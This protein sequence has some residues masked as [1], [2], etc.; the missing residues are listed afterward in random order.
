MLD[1]ARRYFDIARHPVPPEMRALLDARFAE[2]PEDLRGPRQTMGR[3]FTHCGYTLGAAY[4]SFGCTHCYLPRNANRAPLPSLDEMKAQIDANRRLMGP[5]GGLQL[6]GGDVVDAYWRAEKTDELVEIVRY[7]IDAEVEPMI[8]THGQ[9]LLD[10]PEYLD[11]LVVEGG[12]RKLA[13]HIDITQAGR[14]GFPLRELSNE[15]DLHPL[16]ER[17]VDLVIGCRERTGERFFAAHTVT[18]TERNLDSIAEIPRWLLADPRRLEAFRMVSFQTEAAVGRTRFSENPV[19]PETTWARICEGVGIPLDRDNVT[20]G[21]PDCSNMTTVMAL[22]PERRVVNLMP[23][24]DA[25]KAFAEVYLDTIRRLGSRGHVPFERNLRRLMMI[26]R[27]PHFLVAAWRWARERL[28]AE[29]LGRLRLLRRVARGDAR[30]LNVVIHNF[31]GEQMVA[32]GGE[33]VEKRLAACS[34]RGAVRRGDGWE[35]VPMCAMNSGER[36]ALYD[37]QIAAASAVRRGERR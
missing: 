9:V 20:I 12:L 13:L 29:G 2:L 17:F 7:A 4:C 14:P 10:H 11:R 19:T 16:R 24:D 27:R 36:E 25:T 30:F 15:A 18:V 22:F 1:L 6:T 28:R 37:D 3:V 34:L 8:M 21:H 5:T 33:V 31:M 35:A 32:E 23:G 26:A